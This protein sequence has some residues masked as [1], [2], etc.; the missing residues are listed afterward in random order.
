M[1]AEDDDHCARNLA[2]PPNVL[3][4]QLPDR[5]RCCAQGEKDGTEPQYEENR[6]QHHRP[7]HP[8]VAP[9]QFLDAGTRDQ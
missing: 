6:V 9:L 8:A 7:H 3:P 1:Q 4:H 2:Q 5:R